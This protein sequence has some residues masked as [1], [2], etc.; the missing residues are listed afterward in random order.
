[1]RELG[2]KTVFEITGRNSEQRL[3]ASWP[4][5]TPQERIDGAWLPIADKQ[6]NARVACMITAAAYWKAHPDTPLDRLE[7]QVGVA[8]RTLE[9]TEQHWVLIGDDEHSVGKTIY[10][11][12]LPLQEL[13]LAF[14]RAI[15][16]R[17]PRLPRCG[18]PEG[19]GG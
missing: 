16:G 7:E 3:H 10:I 15:F 19:A 4:V 6:H 9:E 8:V 17:F 14:R 18:D 5:Y 11:F 1:M 13:P 12:D 2:G